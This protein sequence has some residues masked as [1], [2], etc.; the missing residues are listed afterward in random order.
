MR[1]EI[2]KIQGSYP[3]AGKSGRWGGETRAGRG[4][5]QAKPKRQQ[6]RRYFSETQAL[7]DAVVKG[8]AEKVSRDRLR[9]HF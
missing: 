7:C 2:W 6:T 8:E 3:R 1:D 5:A 9:K 4:R